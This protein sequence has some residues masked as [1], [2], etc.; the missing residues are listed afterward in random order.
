M[1]LAQLVTGPSIVAPTNGATNLLTQAGDLLDGDTFTI[2]DQSTPPRTL[3]FEFDSGPD[4][5]LNRGAL[6]VRDGQTFTLSDGQG[7]TKTFEFDSGPVMI[8]YG[9]GGTLGDLNTKTFNV[10]DDK[11]VNTLFEFIEVTNPVTAPIPGCLVVNVTP[12]LVEQV[13]NAAINAIN[14][15]GFDAKAALGDISTPANPNASTW[16]RVSL[17]GDSVNPAAGPSGDGIKTEGSY[18]VAAGNIAIPF[19]ETYDDATFQAKE[20]ATPANPTASDLYEGYPWQGQFV[21]EVQ[22]IIEAAMP[23]LRPSFS[24]RNFQGNAGSPSTAG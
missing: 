12:G 10:T 2:T 8:F 14:A 17:I 7:T 20:T 22:S 21:A 4:I 1:P 3:T 6:A 13:A 11:G 18:G 5:D 24:P 9:D 19:K 16:A 15:A 23:K